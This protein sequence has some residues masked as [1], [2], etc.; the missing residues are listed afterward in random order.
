[1]QLLID[2]FT[3]TDRPWDGV[4]GN[5]PKFGLGALSIAFDVAFILQHFVFY[6]PTEPYKAERRMLD[7]ED[8]LLS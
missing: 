2:S 5:L 7:E 3:A 8:P 4:K 6:G 1:V